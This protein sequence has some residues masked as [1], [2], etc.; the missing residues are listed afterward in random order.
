M[1]IERSR[2]PNWDAVIVAFPHVLRTHGVLFAWGDTIFNPDGVQVSA[3]THAHEEEHS[4][5]QAKLGSVEVW[6]DH[7]IKD[8]AFRFGEELP[9]HQVEYAKAYQDARHRNERRFYLN[10]IAGRLAGPLYGRLVNIDTAKGLLK[11]GAQTLI[12]QN[13]EGIAA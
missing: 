10:Q 3:I 4:V 6:W 9:A 7:Y 13:P 2:P 8:P 11:Q 12:S 1:R 5:R